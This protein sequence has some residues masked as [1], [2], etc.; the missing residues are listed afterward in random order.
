MGGER[1]GRTTL[2]GNHPALPQRP[3]QQLK[4]RLLKQ[5]LRGA[6]RVATIGDNDIELIL[7]ILEELESV[8]NVHRYGRVLEPN[9]HSGE[10][11]FG[12]ADD[13]FVNVAEDGGFDG[14]VL[15]YF[16]Q[17]AAVAAADDKDVFGVGVGV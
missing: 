17:D 5:R 6:L 2:G 8:A 13:G 10:V 15:D 4:I 11:L 3:K 7:A 16:A 12:E 1:K 9:G 14:R